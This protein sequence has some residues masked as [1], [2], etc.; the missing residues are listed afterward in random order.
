M[1]KPLL[2]CISPVRARA[3]YGSHSRDI[4]RSLI[5]L[6]KY[7]IKILSIRWGTTPLNVLKPGIDDDILSRLLL[8]PELSKKPEITVQISVPNEYNGDL[9]LFNIGITAGVETT[10]CSPQWLE[11]LNRMNFNIVPSKSAKSV[12]ENSVY[13]KKDQMGNIVSELRCQK[14]IYVLFEG[15]DTNVFKRNENITGNIKRKLNEFPEDFLFLFVG[16]WLNGELG[17]DRKDTGMLIK[18]FLETFKNKL[19][20]P[21]LLLKTGNTFSYTERQEL[22]AKVNRIKNVIQGDLP[23]I[24]I[25]FGDLTQEE[26]NDLYNHTKVK[27]HIT[28]TKGEGFG[29][30]LLEASLSEKPIIASGWSGHLDFLPKEKAILLPGTISQ[31]HPSAVWNGVIEPNS[32]WFNVN[33]SYASNIMTDVWKN[34]Q[35]YVPMAKLLAQENKEKFSLDKMVEELDKL[36]N[37]HVPKFA[38]QKTFN[39]PQLPRLT[40]IKIKNEG[41]EDNKETEEI[42]EVQEKQ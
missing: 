7:D 19:N 40:P 2:L 20:K 38:E 36:F 41:K 30:P 9:G 21:A 29:R 14:P 12:F 13:G 39:I 26:M 5:K 10:I 11:G 23:N 32:Q 42:K 37:E 31:V 1:N 24:Y 27:V 22:L 8:R 16:H 18:I 34:Y 4:V 25:L 35:K 28:F 3:G 15:V 17:A 6:N 33:Y